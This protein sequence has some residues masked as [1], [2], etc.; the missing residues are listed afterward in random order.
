MVKK[1]VHTTKNLYRVRI[2]SPKVCDVRSF[3]VKILSK[4]KGIKATV[5]CPV[6]EFKRGKCEVG[7]ILQSI[8][9]DKKKFTKKQAEKHAKKTF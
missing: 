1:K 5:C 7:T 6:G 9:Y 2:K 3:R 4:K 8:L